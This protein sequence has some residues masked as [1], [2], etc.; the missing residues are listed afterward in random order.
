[1]NAALRVIST[2]SADISP[3]SARLETG[4]RRHRVAG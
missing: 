4:H 1:M 2:E 3:D